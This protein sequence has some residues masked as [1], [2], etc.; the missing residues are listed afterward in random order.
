VIDGF[1]NKLIFSYSKLIFTLQFQQVW[2][3]NTLIWHF[4]LFQL[5]FLNIVYV[6]IN[7]LAKRTLFGYECWHPC[8]YN[9]IVD[10]IH[11]SIAENLFYIENYQKFSNK[12][13]DSYNCNKLLRFEISFG[14]FPESP[15]LPLMVLQ[16]QQETPY[17]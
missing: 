7:I 12:G 1:V 16:I 3:L 5:F 15:G 2:T 17:N 8:I 6:D 14:R 13:F 10:F 9:L 11:M 4:Q